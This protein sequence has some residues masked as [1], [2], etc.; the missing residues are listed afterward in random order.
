M[1]LQVL[2]GIDISLTSSGKSTAA[3]SHWPDVTET[4]TVAWAIGDDAVVTLE[5]SN[6]LVDEGV[7]L[8]LVAAW[9][10]SVDIIDTGELGD[11]DWLAVLGHVVF[12]ICLRTRERVLVDVDRGDVPSGELLTGGFAREF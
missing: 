1:N 2:D 11:P 5:E 4:K 7:D 8:A 6:N 9:S 3:V 10:P 12:D